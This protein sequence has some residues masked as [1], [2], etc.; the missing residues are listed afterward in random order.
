MKLIDALEK[1]EVKEFGKPE[2]VLETAISKLFFFGNDVVK[3]YKHGKYFFANLED[4]APR[5]KFFQDDF[6]WN[7][8]SSPEIY[9]ELGAM[10]NDTF[11]KVDVSKGD[12]FFILMRKIDSSATFTRLLEENTLTPEDTKRMSIELIELLR[13]LTDK[14]LKDFRHLTKM[15]WRQLWKEDTTDSLRPWL[16]MANDHIPKQEAERIMDILEDASEKEKYFT[17]Y[18]GN[19]FAVVIDNNCDNLLFLDGKPSF[20]DIMPPKEGWRVADEFSTVIRTAVDAYV[21]GGPEHGKMV[22]DTYRQYRE[23]PPE[24][25]TLIYEVRAALIQ[26]PYRHILGQHDLAEK[27][28]GYVLPRI[29]KLKKIYS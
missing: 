5:R 6:S 20:I 14:K 28:K 19:L 22:Y 11:E 25:V 10:R 15:G 13:V 2:N 18:D 7:H 4:L 1:G 21:I 27:F 24:N 26:W 9:K 16:D 17:H 12:D 3:V 8:T 23:E 29:E